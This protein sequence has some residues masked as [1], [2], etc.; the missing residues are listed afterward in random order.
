M[1]S[2]KWVLIL[3]ITQCL[4]CWVTGALVIILRKKRSNGRGNF[5]PT[6]IKLIKTDCMLPS[7]KE[8][9]R[10][11]FRAMKR[12]LMN[13]KNGLMKDVSFPG[14]RKIIFGRWVIQVLVDPAPRFILI[15]GQRKKEKR[16]MEKL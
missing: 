15:A 7:S 1:I 9:Q 5:L 16:L 4:K 14:K 2:K 13:G 10:K 12:L 6:F 11:I 3:I 8:M